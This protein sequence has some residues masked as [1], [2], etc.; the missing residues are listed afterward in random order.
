M[1]IQLT[2]VI[3]FLGGIIIIHYI[4][5]T[6]NIALKIFIRNNLWVDATKVCDV[7]KIMV[8]EGEMDNGGLEKIILW[9]SILKELYTWSEWIIFP[10]SEQA[11]FL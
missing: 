11:S 1:N 5:N 10:K 3:F 4:V 8:A 9:V 7:Q 6:T 2:C